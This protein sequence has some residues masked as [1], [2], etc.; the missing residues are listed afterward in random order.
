MFL[1]IQTQAQ[2]TALNSS[3]S[4]NGAVLGAINTSTSIGPKVLLF[5]NFTGTTGLVSPLAII[6][7]VSTS[8]YEAVTGLNPATDQVVGAFVGTDGLIRLYGKFE[9]N[10]NYYGVAI[11][12]G[13]NNC[14]VDVNFKFTGSNA[15]SQKIDAAYS[16]TIT[17]VYGANLT[18]LNGVSLSA[19]HSVA[20]FDGV[21][22]T[23]QNALVPSISGETPSIKNFRWD[24]T[25]WLIL[26]NFNKLGTTDCFDIARWD[27][28][29]ITPINTT[30]TT[31]VYCKDYDNGTLGWSGVTTSNNI[32]S[33]G[34]LGLN[35]GLYGL[36]G[37]WYTL[38]QDVQVFDQETWICG[39]LLGSAG[40]SNRSRIASY[41]GSGWINREGNLTTNSTSLSLTIYG[42]VVADNDGIP[43]II[44][45]GN[46]LQGTNSQFQYVARYSPSAAPVELK[47][48]TGKAVNENNV[49]T[50]ITETENQNVGFVIQRS[51]D[52]IN[53]DSL[54]FIKSKA[55][56]GFSTTRI[57]YNYLDHSAYSFYYR[58]VQIDRD[59]K[60]N[61]SNIVYIDRDIENMKIFPNPVVL[62]N[63]NITFYSNAEKTLELSI[64]D[65][66]GNLIKRYFIE[67]E[68]GEN[69]QVLSLE[70][71]AGIY[72]VKFENHILKIIKG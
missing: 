18:S 45:Y 68:R 61:I 39:S 14:F 66:T 70:I 26:G 55:I 17:L 50:W 53:Y 56:N 48:F 57:D 20:S 10:S 54:T 7:D 32:T 44:A 51:I 52:G 3:A 22:T 27:G 13:I 36:S 42:M 47:S 59:G 29:V 49:L 34:A 28:S 33:P 12:D 21:I 19:G 30:T 25:N 24:G 71:P 58:L 60:T 1:A 2:W 43:V 9:D 15:M 35:T 8:S 38:T 23:N 40:P 63:I 67:I 6:Y 41:G 31:N 72:L 69:S 37:G 65:V 64:I 4:P 11:F 16:S 46:L 5:G 62:N